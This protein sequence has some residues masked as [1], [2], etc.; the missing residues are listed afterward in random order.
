MENRFK[1]INYETI[2]STND[3]CK[4]LAISAQDTQNYVITA[5]TQSRGRGAKQNTWHSLSGN[6]HMSVL[7]RNYKVEDVN[8]EKFILDTSEC[9]RNTIL[10]FKSVN[11]TTKAPNDVLINNKKVAGILVEQVHMDKNYSL[12][13]GIGVNT[14]YIPNDAQINA[15]SLKDE[16]VKVDTNILANKIVNALTHIVK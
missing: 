15:T 10:S 11:I 4:R 13:I 7:L 5:D 3:E 6:L 16:G 8:L 1:F 14:T 12:I 2:D 9:V